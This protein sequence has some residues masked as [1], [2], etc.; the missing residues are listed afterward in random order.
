MN[1][2]RMLEELTPFG[3]IDDGRETI[4]SWDPDF[5]MRPLDDY[6]IVDKY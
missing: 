2:E 5:G 3:F 4:D 1:E 6:W